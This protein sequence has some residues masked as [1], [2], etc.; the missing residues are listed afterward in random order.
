MG[1]EVRKETAWV[2]SWS[3]LFDVGASAGR[4][5]KLE[6]TRYRAGILAGL[7]HSL[8]WHVDAHSWLEPQPEKS[9]TPACGLSRQAA[10]HSP[11]AGAKRGCPREPERSCIVFYDRF[12]KHDSG[13]P[14][15]VRDSPQF[16][17]REHRPHFSMGEVR[18]GG[19]VVMAIFGE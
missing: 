14:T 16:K 7:L 5:Q 2:G 4:S 11:A 10:F 6:V 17:V 18:V 8:T 15:T 19:G 1:L 9:R 12:V 3:L 13:A